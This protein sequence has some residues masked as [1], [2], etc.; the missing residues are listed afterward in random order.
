MN[1]KLFTYLLLVPN[2]SITF[3]TDD[4][5]VAMA[6]ALILGGGQTGVIRMDEASGIEIKIPSLTIFDTN[7]SE[8]IELYLEMTLAK[9]LP[10]HEKE[11][12]KCLET[13]AYT[14]LDNRKAFDEK[15][16][17]K[18][19][20]ERNKFLANHAEK[21]QGQYSRW[22]TLAWSYARAINNKNFMESVSKN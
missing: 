20:S 1:K 2:E 18:K 4:D 9:Y 13:F 8:T 21:N 10:A 14:T 3:K 19:E 22:V 17:A 7:A 12:G 5:K 6:C 15:L 11:M 16:F